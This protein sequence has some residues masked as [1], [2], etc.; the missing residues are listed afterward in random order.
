MFRRCH[1]II[2]SAFG[3]LLAGCG[4]SGPQIAEVTGLVTLDNSP[5]AGALVSFEPT[6]PGRTSVGNTDESGRYRLQFT[7]DR[8]GALPGEHNVRIS[9][10]QFVFDEERG[11]DVPQPERVPPVYNTES[12]LKATVESSGSEV[13]F[14]LESGDFKSK[15]PNLQN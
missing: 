6:G 1:L 15:E 10:K 12:T 14:T 5:L 11:E 3:L 2:G 4:E 7:P 9:T 13:D 8:Y